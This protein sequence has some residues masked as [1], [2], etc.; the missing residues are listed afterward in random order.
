[1]NTR[2]NCW[3]WDVFTSLLSLSLLFSLSSFEC[4]SYTLM[5]FPLVQVCRA[6]AIFRKRNCFGG[7][8]ISTAA[9]LSASPFSPNTIC[10]LIH[11]LNTD[12]Q[13]LRALPGFS[14]RSG[15]NTFFFKKKIALSIQNP[16]KS[17][18][19]CS[20]YICLGKHMHCLRTI[21]S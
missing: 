17:S 12:M 14:W 1:M 13:L 19:S 10:I 3:Q 21:C 20:R 11:T 7:N 9:C 6:A 8:P 18:N 2:P 5:L 15:A 4:M 16:L